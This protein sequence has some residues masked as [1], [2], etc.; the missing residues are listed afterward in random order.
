MD[1]YI[2]DQLQKGEE[3]KADVGDLISFEYFL[4][5]YKTAIVWNRVKF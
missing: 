1:K 4:K 2:E 3:A 5:I